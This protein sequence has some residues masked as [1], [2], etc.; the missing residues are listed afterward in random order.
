MN[1]NSDKRKKHKAES[2][3]VHKTAM[4]PAG[5]IKVSQLAQATISRMTIGTL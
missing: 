3:P 1:N 2:K 5:K 4:V